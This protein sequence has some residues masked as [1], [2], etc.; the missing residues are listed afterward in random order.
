MGYETICLHK[1]FIIDRIVS[2]HY[3]EY[4]ST[5]AFEGERHDFWELLY[6][7]KGAVLV[8]ADDREHTLQKGQIIFHKPGEFHSLRSC[9]G[10]APN[11]VVAGFVCT[12]PHM[13]FFEGRIEE[14]GSTGRALLAAIVSEAAAAFSSHLGDPQVLRL[15]RR[16]NAPFG[17]EQLI[18]CSLEQLLLRLVRRAHRMKDTPQAAPLL[19]NHTPRDFVTGI[20]RY[21]Q[22]NLHRKLSLSDICRDNLVGRSYLQK[23]FSRAYRRRCDGIFWNA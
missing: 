18:A 12:S 4:T 14:L 16:A 9:G 22:A 20:T 8:H 13:R 6:V 1:P 3:F 15:E 5:Y 2:I 7:D 10:T 19:H 11:L 23:N 17:C 21:L